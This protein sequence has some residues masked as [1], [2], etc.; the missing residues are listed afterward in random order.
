MEMDSSSPRLLKLLERL[1]PKH[2]L[3]L[4]GGLFLL[5][6]FVPDPIFL[7]DEVI[8]GFLTLLLARWKLRAPPAPAASKPPPKNV[9]PP[10]PPPP[11]PPAE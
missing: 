3:L 5:D 11:P 9:T 2:L 10:D 1:K 8:L 7:V 4:V 6:V